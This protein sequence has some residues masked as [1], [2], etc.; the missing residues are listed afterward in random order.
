MNIYSVD[1]L[2]SE[3]DCHKKE[4]LPHSRQVSYI[5]NGKDTM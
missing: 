3:E 4:K 2:S 5:Q 1:A